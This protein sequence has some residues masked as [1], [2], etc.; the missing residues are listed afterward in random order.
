MVEI[1]W[2]TKNLLYT[3]VHLYT[4]LWALLLKLF[5]NWIRL[6]N[7][8]VCVGSKTN[9]NL[10]RDICK[11]IYFYIINWDFKSRMWVEYWFVKFR[12]TL[13]CR[14]REGKRPTLGFKFE[15]IIMH[16]SATKL[17]ALRTI[18]LRSIPKYA[19][20]FFLI[21]WCFEVHKYNLWRFLKK[22]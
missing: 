13:R 7:Q 6:I 11:T 22:F 5:I 12:A 16:N 10:K 15:N 14:P 8:F 20:V 18:S 21:K 19:T 9:H 2:K 3:S 4:S 17:I 1:F